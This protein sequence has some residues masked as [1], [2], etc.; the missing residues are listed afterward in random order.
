MAARIQTKRRPPGIQSHVHGHSIYRS[1]PQDLRAGCSP[2]S[3]STRF[4]PSMRGR[5]GPGACRFRDARRRH[6]LLPGVGSRSSRATPAA[7][8]TENDGVTDHPAQ[9]IHDPAKLTGSARRTAAARGRAGAS[10]SA[11]AAGAS[12]PTSISRSPC[13]AQTALRGS[14]CPQRGAPARRRVQVQ[15]SCRGAQAATAASAS[16]RRGDA[17]AVRRVFDDAPAEAI[18]GLRETT[19]PRGAC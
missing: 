2:P 5:R 8:S 1:A 18:H 9:G 6:D 13:A 10:P 7:T 16:L 12:A 19:R 17:A 14:A 15:P 4:N 11:D 3:L